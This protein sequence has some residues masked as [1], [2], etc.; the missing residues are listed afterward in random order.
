MNEC[1]EESARIEGQEGECR[2]G[3]ARKGVHAQGE[4]RRRNMK[5][6]ECK[7]TTRKVQ[8]GEWNKGSATRVVQ[9]GECKNG[10]VRKGART[11][12]GEEEGAK[13]KG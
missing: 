12:R 9:R 5:E 7:C 8:E 2:E 1:Q 11:G 13:G 6:E 4:E 3:K 10:S